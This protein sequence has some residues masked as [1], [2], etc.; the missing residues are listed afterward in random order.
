MRVIDA[1]GRTVLQDNTRWDKRTQLNLAGLPAGSYTVQLQS[2]YGW[3]HLQ[4]IQR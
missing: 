4:L 1:V 3:H 2:D